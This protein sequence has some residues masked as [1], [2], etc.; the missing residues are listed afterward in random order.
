MLCSAQDAIAKKD[1][2]AGW[3]VLVKD[4]QLMVPAR[5]QH[6]NARAR[7]STHTLRVGARVHQAQAQ[8][9]DDAQMWHGV[10]E[11]DLAGTVCRGGG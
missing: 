5:T 4:R 11:S 9:E 3:T 8:C 6:T 1:S 10:S 2:M 7:A